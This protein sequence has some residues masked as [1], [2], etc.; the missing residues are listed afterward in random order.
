MDL[1]DSGHSESEFYYPEEETLNQ[2]T[3][4]NR[5]EVEQDR[6]FKTTF[7]KKSTG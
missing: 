7:K 3:P 1:D 6:H 2:T 5:D 4:T